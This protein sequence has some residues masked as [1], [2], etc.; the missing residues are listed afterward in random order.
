MISRLRPEASY[1]ELLSAPAALFSS[2]KW[3]DEFATLLTRELEL[4]NAPILTASGRAALYYLFMGHPLEVVYLPAYTCWV[5]LEAARLADKE[6]VF[7]DVDY[8]SFD[9]PADAYEGIRD[10]PGIVIATHQFGYP[11]DV[12]QLRR[13]LGGCGHFIVEDCAG[14]LFSQH[15]GRALGQMGDAAIYSFEMA[16]LWTIGGGALVYRDPELNEKVRAEVNGKLRSSSS[17]ATL[18]AI[19]FR[20]LA[21]E[22][23]YYRWL[24]ALYLQR[25]EPTAGEQTGAPTLDRTYTAVFGNSQARLG[26]QMAKRINAIVEQRRMLFDVYFSGIQEIPGLRPVPAPPASDICPIRFPFLVEQ[27]DKNALYQ[28]MRA[29]GVDLGFSFTYSLADE[30]RYP[31]A[32]RIAREIMNLP[33][34]SAITFERARGILANLRAVMLEKTN[35][36]ARQ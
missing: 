19:L 13:I 15:R 9:V 20:K 21:T 36:S 33:V 4:P 27:G 1:R 26:M 31:G 22:P 12:A 24:L 5:V 17:A 23:V 35:R 6:V 3:C 29:R 10:R 11:V 2:R 18:L 14:A 16:K 25:H 28:A 34:Y 32:A 30:V 7:L 8:P